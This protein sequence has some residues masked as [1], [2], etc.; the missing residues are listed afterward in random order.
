[1]AQ[2]VLPTVLSLSHCPYYRKAEQK[3]MAWGFDKLF[4][5]VKSKDEYSLRSE[6]KSYLGGNGTYSRYKLGRRML[7][8]E[9]QERIIEMFQKRGYGEGLEFDHYVMVFDFD[10]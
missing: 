8:P 5:E 6:M 7:T 10:H 9:Q 2:T 1:M 4:A 3:R